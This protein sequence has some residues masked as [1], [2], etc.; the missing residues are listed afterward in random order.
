MTNAKIIVTAASVNAPIFS[1]V[2]TSMPSPDEGA[3][4]CPGNGGGGGGGG[5]GGRDARLRPSPLA[6]PVD[7]PLSQSSMLSP[8]VSG[9]S[10][11]L[12]FRDNVP[13]RLEDG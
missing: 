10:L 12:L 8:Q 5:G 9:L 1:N 7:G 6:E 2:P 3:P 11:P 13:C 4:G